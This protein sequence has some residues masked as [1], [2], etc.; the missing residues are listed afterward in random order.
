ML[1]FLLGRLIS[2][3]SFFTVDDGYRTLQQEGGES[4]PLRS[5]LTAPRR[6]GGFVLEAGDQ[7]CKIGGKGRTVSSDPVCVERTSFPPVNHTDG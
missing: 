1:L 7:W 6:P 3:A 2:F 4:G 5:S